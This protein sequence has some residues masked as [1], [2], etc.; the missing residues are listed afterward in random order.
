MGKGQQTLQTWLQGHLHPGQWSSTFAVQ[1][2]HGRTLKMLMPKCLAQEFW[3]NWSG[4]WLARVNL[5]KP[6]H[7]ILRG[8]SKSCTL[9]LRQRFSKFSTEKSHLES[10][11][12]CR[13]L[14]LAHRRADSVALKWSLRI[15]I[16]TSP[17]LGTSLCPKHDPKK[18][19]T[20]SR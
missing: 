2:N 9:S 11:L 1:R 4:V 6:P 13:F 12:K 5:L 20:H 7:V 15:C 10:F 17:S 19:K 14:G 16:L 18:K 3:F 8:N